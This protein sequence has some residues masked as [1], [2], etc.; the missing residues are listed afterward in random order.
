MGDVGSAAEERHEQGGV[1]RVHVIHV[2]RPLTPREEELTPLW[3]REAIPID[4]AGG[5]PLPFQIR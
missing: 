4:R 5:E 1:G 2:R 3:F